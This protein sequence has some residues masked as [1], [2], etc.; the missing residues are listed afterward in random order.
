[1]DDLLQRLTPIFRD[2][3]DND[4]L[5]LRDDLTA[6]DVEE[7]DSLNHVKLVIAI[8]NGFKVKFTTREIS[9]WQNVGDMK[10]TLQQK[11]AKA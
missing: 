10:R 1:M 6:K 7:W 4:A 8:E 5:A 2:V 11:L 9:S 3:L